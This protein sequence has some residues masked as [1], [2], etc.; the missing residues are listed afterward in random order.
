M[1]NLLYNYLETKVKIP[2]IRHGK[3]Q[4]IE[5]LINEESLLL[6]KTSIKRSSNR[7]IRYGQM[8]SI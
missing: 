1:L 7:T 2:R 3:K 5:T 8:L 6:A 4:T